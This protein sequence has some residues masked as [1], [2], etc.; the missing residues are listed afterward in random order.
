MI[1]TVII[2]DEM[3]SR[4]AMREMLKL[5]CTGV[6][7]VAEADGVTSGIE[8]IIQHQPKLVMLD[9]KMPDGTGFD[10]ISKV[11]P[12]NFHVIFVTAFEDF[13]LKAF[14]ANAID[15]L[16]KPIDPAELQNAI[17]KASAMIGK[18]DLDDRL[19]KMF[20]DYTRFQVPE[21]RKIVLKTAEA[22]HIVDV[23]NIVR[24]ESDRNYT[25]FF[26]EDKTKIM[27]SKTIRDYS[28]MLEPFNFFRIHHSHLINMKF[29]VKLRR[30]E[31][32]CVLKD[33]TEIPVATRKRDELIRRLK[34]I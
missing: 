17:E 10:L 15:Y 16:T 14:R 21:N 13:A 8:A 30:D 3:R 6:E 11:M 19:K 23:D 20:A 29:L 1:T 12:V 27:M 18:E 9:I 7:V 28:E 2:D 34:A 24:C 26:M 31:L 4:D 5:Y 25:N 22:I 33:G 32:I